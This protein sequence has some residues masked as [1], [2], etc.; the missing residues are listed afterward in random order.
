QVGADIIRPYRMDNVCE[1]S[2]LP[3]RDHG[4]R[5]RQPT[6]LHE[7]EFPSAAFYSFSVQ[8]AKFQSQQAALISVTSA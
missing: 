5:L 7:G 2:R 4:S 8:A 3:I 6:K 1:K